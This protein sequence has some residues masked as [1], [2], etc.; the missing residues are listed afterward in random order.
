MQIC[1]T[2]SISLITL[3]TSLIQVGIGVMTEYNRYGFDLHAIE[4]IGQI[5]RDDTG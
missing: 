2:I 4:A 5:S 3:S 1:K